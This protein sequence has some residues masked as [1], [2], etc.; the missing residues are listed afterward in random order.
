MRL[1]QELHRMVWGL[2]NA[3]AEH[4][5]AIKEARDLARAVG[6][7]KPF[8]KELAADWMRKFGGDRG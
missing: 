2:A 5:R 1:E 4:Q 7:D 6:D 8:V 3:S